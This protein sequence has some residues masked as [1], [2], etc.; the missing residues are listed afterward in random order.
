[1][2]KIFIAPH[3]YHIQ[4]EGFF[5]QFNLDRRALC[6]SGKERCSECRQLHTTAGTRQYRGDWKAWGHSSST[7]KEKIVPSPHLLLHPEPPQPGTVMGMQKSLKAS[8]TPHWNHCRSSQ[9]SNGDFTFFNYFKWCLQTLAPFCFFLEDER[10]FGHRKV[11]AHQSG[12]KKNTPCSSQFIGKWWFST[13]RRYSRLSVKQYQTNISTTCSTFLHNSLLTIAR[14]N[15]YNVLLLI[16]WI[17]TANVFSV[18]NNAVIRT[19][20]RKNMW[21]CNTYQI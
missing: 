11:T 6:G 20:L 16:S 7:L 5:K 14:E 2:G 19:A 1:M 12:G 4:P 15:L 10:E 17:F 3:C 13:K 9:G 21:Q 18:K 8:L